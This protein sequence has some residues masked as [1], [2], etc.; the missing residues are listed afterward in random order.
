MNLI[1]QAPKRTRVHRYFMAYTTMG[2]SRLW[3]DEINRVWV[4]ETEPGGYYS[5]H[6]PCRTLKAFKRALRKHRGMLKGHYVV[7][8]NRFQGHDVEVKDWA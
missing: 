3:W 4:E 5:T 2:D 7:L 1:F 6:A 8:V